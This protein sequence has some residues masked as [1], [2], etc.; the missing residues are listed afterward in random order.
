MPSPDPLPK[1]PIEELDTEE[2]R[3]LM[4]RRKSLVEAARLRIE[5]EE[6]VINPQ[7][8]RASKR[9]PGEPEERA[10]MRVRQAQ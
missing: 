5:A 2:L 7:S 9:V 4:Q 3:E 6:G 1:S 10:A 8:L